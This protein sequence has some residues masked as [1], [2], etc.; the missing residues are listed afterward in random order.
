MPG[1]GGGPNKSQPGGRNFL[2]AKGNIRFR[3]PFL[4]SEKE[5]LRKA[6]AE[7]GKEGA[8]VCFTRGTLQR[9]T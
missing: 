9:P 2:R 5:A 6:T 7:L 1:T 4:S 8:G 3:N